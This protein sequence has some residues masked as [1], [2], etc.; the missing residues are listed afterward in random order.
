[1]AT[2]EVGPKSNLVVYEMMPTRRRKAIPVQIASQQHDEAV[3]LAFSADGKL[4]A[5]LLPEMHAAAAPA[6]ELGSLNSGNTPTMHTNPNGYSITVYLWRTGKTLASISLGSPSLPAISPQVC[7][8][9]R[10]IRSRSP[11]SLKK[12]DRKTLA[13]DLKLACLVPNFIL[14]DDKQ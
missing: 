8:A 1:M 5:T 12:K 10:H 2:L 7:E 13:L 9:Q 4:L 11:C 14:H 6:A 3:A